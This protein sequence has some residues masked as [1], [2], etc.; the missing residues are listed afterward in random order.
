[1]STCRLHG[2]EVARREL[3]ELARAAARCSPVSAAASP[4]SAS[5]TNMRSRCSRRQRLEAD[6]EREAA[7]RRLVEV[8]EQ[9]GG[10]DE[11]AGEALHALQHLVDLAHLVVALGHAAAAQEAVGLVEQQHRASRSAPPRTSAPCSARSRRRTCS[12]GRAPGAPSAAAAARAR[13]AR[14][15][16]SCRCPAARRSTACRSRGGAAPRRSCGTSKRDSM[17]S[18]LRS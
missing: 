11:D 12:P 14:P 6:L 7:Q 13:C 1:M 9:V 15:A 10:A 8:V 5:A 16:P 2:G 17:F 18:R 4:S 3:V